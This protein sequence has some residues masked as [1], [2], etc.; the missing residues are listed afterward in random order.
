M[1]DPERKHIENLEMPGLKRNPFSV[2]EGY[3]AGLEDSLH[4]KMHRPQSG[5]ATAVLK[6]KPAIILALMF[7]II[8]GFGYAV[9]KITG[10]IYT[11][12]VES[13]D[14]IL[15]MI[16]EGWLESSFIYA[17]SDEIDIETAFNNFL[18]DN[19]TIDESISEELEASITE[20]DIIRYQYE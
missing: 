11:D 16:Q 8:A 20:E 18:E 1:R 15:A 17:Y 14:P 6:V 19:V 7:G 9:S 5:L 3:F 10:L 13:G 12:P 2:P 4:E